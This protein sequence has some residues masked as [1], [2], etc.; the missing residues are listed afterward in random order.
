MPTVEDL[1][2]LSEAGRVVPGGPVSPIAVW[3]WCRTGL[4]TP[5][6]R[7]A[8][9][10]SYKAGRRLCTTR[11]DLIEFFTAAGSSGSDEII[12]HPDTKVNF[13]RTH[14]DCRV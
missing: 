14:N 8:V 3:R 11:A 12:G 4:K 7:R 13:T 9:L 6:G 2:T 5:D 10:K 1:L